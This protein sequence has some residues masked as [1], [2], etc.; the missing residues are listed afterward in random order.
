M[1]FAAVILALKDIQPGEEITISYIDEEESLEERR[2]ALADY[3]FVCQCEKCIAES[4][5]TDS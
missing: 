4:S 1:V 2:A 5:S 3:G